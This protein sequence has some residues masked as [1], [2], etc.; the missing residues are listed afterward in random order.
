MAARAR[1]P[2]GA[3]VSGACALLLAGCVAAAPAPPSRARPVTRADEH[4]LELP[5]T[6]PATWRAALA[7]VQG[8][9]RALER[10]VRLWPD[11]VVATL[12]A[13]SGGA[14]PEVVRAFE[15]V[16]GGEPAR[17]ASYAEA[18]ARV[19]AP[20]GAEALAAL[21]DELDRPAGLGA[22][23]AWEGGLLLARERTRAGDPSGA[24]DAW[25]TALVRGAGVRDPLLLEE[26][27]AERP[28]GAA[29]PGPPAP[30]SESEAL[31]ALARMRLARGQG[32]LALVAAVRAR[33]LA[34]DEVRRASAALEL[35]RASH[36]LGR[37]G[38]AWLALEEAGRSSEAPV[39]AAAAALAGAMEVERDDFPAARIRFEQAV[40]E[41]AWPGRGRALSDLGAVLLLLGEEHA[42]L[43]RLAE[44][45]EL[46]QSQ[47]DLAGLACALRNRAAYLRQ[48]QRADEAAELQLRVA[49]L[50]RIDGRS[51]SR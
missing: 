41:A 7:E 50:E 29:W 45:A 33:A 24:A 27:I 15:G 47:D 14:A 25:R 36:A 32:E 26:A 3:R 9:P 34:E 28:V 43:A 46:C 21:A 2:S 42:G 1:S 12:R 10:F 44:A 16:F 37:P 39:R 49:E 8:N 18:R 4:A 6:D 5:E 51:A 17:T 11:E 48:A 35:A 31:T 13:S 30:A 38:E 22:H 40:A 20:G 23:A 19:L